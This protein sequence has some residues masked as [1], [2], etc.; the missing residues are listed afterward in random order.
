MKRWDIINQ[1]IKQYGLHSYLEIGTQKDDCLQEIKCEFKVGVDPNPIWHSVTASN[2]FY[3]MT[4][5]A[6]FAENQRCFDVIFIDGLHHAD[7]AKKDIENALKIMTQEGAIVVHDCNP[8]LEESQIIPEPVVASWNGD[9]WKA[10][11]SFRNRNNLWMYVWNI[12]HGVGVIRWGVQNNL[13]VP[14][15]EMTWENFDKNRKLWLNLKEII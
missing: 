14:P 15:E 3:K 1:I 8:L 4:S 11:V 12:D 10:W 5:D 2:E 9:V 7:Q 6:F 13:D